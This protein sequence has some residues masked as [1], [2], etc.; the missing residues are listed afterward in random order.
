L[1]RPPTRDACP[2]TRSRGQAT[3]GERKSRHMAWADLMRRCFGLDVLECPKCFGRMKLIALIEDPAVIKKILE[4]L[5]L[6]SEV[7]KA[8][9]AR[10]PP[11]QEYRELWDAVDPVYDDPA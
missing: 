11:E 6:P 2:P 1:H 10:P 4:H 5:N 3:A 7:P 8:R 9:S